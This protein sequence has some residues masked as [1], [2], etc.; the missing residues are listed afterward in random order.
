MPEWFHRLFDHA[1]LD[2][3]QFDRSIN[4][5]FNPK[6]HELFEA[7]AKAFK[8]EKVIEENNLRGV[9][10]STFSTFEIIVSGFSTPDPYLVHYFRGMSLNVITFRSFLF[11]LIVVLLHFLDFLYSDKGHKNSL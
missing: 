9:E 3:Y 6:K 10:I 2:R 5:V 1:E 8:E 11:R 4:A 7:S